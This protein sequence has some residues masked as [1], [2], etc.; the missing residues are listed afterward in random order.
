[1]AVEFIVNGERVSRRAFAAL[2]PLSPPLAAGGTVM[3]AGF[4]LTPRRV[5][6]SEAA[7]VHPMDAA[8]SEEHARKC[9]LN[10]HFDSLGRP[11]FDSL[12]ERDKYL[13]LV[14]YHVKDTRHKKPRKRAKSGV[15]HV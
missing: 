7:A 15:N 1:M 2:P 13:K 11:H 14:G 8:A 6:R 12:R 10:V 3:A 9:G 5:I 4:T